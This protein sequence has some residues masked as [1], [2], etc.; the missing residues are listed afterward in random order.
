MT[1][2]NHMDDNFIDCVITSPPYWGLRDYGT[3]KWEGGDPNC[4]HRIDR[5]GNRKI[6]NATKIDQSKQT[7]LS[8]EYVLINGICPKCGAKRIDLQ[9][10]LEKTPEE[11]VNKMVQ[12][13]REIKRVLKKEGTVWLNLGD[14]YAGSG[15]G[16]NDYRT[17]K[18]RSINKTDN[19]K[20]KD[21]VG[22]PWRVAFALQADGW[23]LR[24]DIIWAKP[25]PM[26]ESVRDRPTKA[27]EYIF[28]L[29][30]SARYYYDADVIR[31]NVFSKSSI[32]RS[33][34]NGG[35]RNYNKRDD[36]KGKPDY[37]SGNKHFW[38]SDRNKR[39]VWTINTQPFPEAHFAVFPEKL[40][41]PC[42]LAGCPEH[43]IIYD[44]F[45]GAGT[46]AKV[47]LRANRQFIGSEI[48][49]EYVKIA[50]KRIEAER[51]QLKLF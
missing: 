35:N 31:E 21:L 13:F 24:S 30:K 11:Y 36:D 38:P 46:T 47:A 19:L 25:N 39:S 6:T 23:W 18:S 41:E 9:I 37:L 49:P 34:Y 42:V 45:M 43:G 4:N 8:G 2:L 1:T 40:I 20:S 22:I 29:T 5:F 12:I 26:P 28:L 48:N 16:T 3:A 32:E 7:S 50:N 10:G 15:C 51:N 14:S 33:K 17:E 44:P 27:H